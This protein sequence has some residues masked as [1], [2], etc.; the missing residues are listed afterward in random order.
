MSTQVP[1]TE[2]SQPMNLTIKGLLYPVIQRRQ[3]HW[4]VF[5]EPL[6]AHRRETLSF[7]SQPGWKGPSHSETNRMYID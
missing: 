7:P 5:Y 1:F 6:R 4:L 3:A 2:T